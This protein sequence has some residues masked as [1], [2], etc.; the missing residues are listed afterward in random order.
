MLALRAYK[1]KTKLLER[2]PPLDEYSLE[3]E[4]RMTRFANKAVTAQYQMVLATEHMH[5]R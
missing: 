3:L 1:A 4:G 2:L 5:L